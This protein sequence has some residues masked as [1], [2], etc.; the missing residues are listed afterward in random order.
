MFAVGVLL[1]IPGLIAA[2]SLLFF[3]PHERPGAWI[4]LAGATLLA[5]VPLVVAWRRMAQRLR[6]GAIALAGV[7]LCLAYW[8]VL[9]LLS[10]VD[11]R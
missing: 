10:M 11:C 6:Y 9:K 7:E 4:V 5:A 2:L 8:A 1:A 3:D